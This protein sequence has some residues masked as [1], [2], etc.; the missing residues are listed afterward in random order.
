[1]RL[2]YVN[3][4]ECGSSLLLSRQA[5]LELGGYDQ[6]LRAQRAQG[7][8]DMLLQLKVAVR[9]PIAVVPEHL[10]GWR[11]HARNMSSDFDQMARSCDLVFQQLAAEGTALPPLVVRRARAKIAFELAEQRASSGRFGSMLW[12]MTRAIALDPVRCSLFLAYRAARSMRRRLGAA[13]PPLPRSRFQE[14]DPAAVVRSDP[15]ELRGFARLLE[16]IEEKRLSR[17][18]AREPQLV[19]RMPLRVTRA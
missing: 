1:M 8:E 13:R 12:W 3:A 19:K 11:L 7:C 9:F 10:V 6:T 4:V 16:R 2:G 14:I 5:A 15:H 18:A 17:L